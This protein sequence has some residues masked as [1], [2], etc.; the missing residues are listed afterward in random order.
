MSKRMELRRK[1]KA[2]TVRR[3][4]AEAFRPHQFQVAKEARI[5]E[6]RT[7]DSRLHSQAKTSRYTKQ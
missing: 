2:K 6:A 4:A 3:V 1:K 7:G 5:R